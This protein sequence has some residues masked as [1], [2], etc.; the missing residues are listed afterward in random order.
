MTTTMRNSVELEDIEDM[1][2]QAGIDDAELHGEIRDLR[3]GSFVRLTFLLGS[4]ICETLS[5]RITSVKG[6]TF[7]GKLAERPAAASLSN[8]V[9]GAPIVFT[10]SHIHSI[11]N[12]RSPRGQ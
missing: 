6:T 8:L 5:V 1:R 11:P 10:A 3:A 2:R 12:M 9:G 7:R 4:K